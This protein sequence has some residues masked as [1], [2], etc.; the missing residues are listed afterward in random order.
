MQ[1]IAKV[2]KLILSN[3]APTTIAKG[4]S[5]GQQSKAKYSLDAAALKEAKSR[6]DAL[7]QKY[8]LYPELDLNILE[9]I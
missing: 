2:V 8:T 7:L 5:A 3:T 1:E 6:V 9:K 4:K